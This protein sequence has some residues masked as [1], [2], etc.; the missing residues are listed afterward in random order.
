VDDVV[1]RGIVEAVDGGALMVRIPSLSVDA[2]H[3]AET[4]TAGLVAGDRVAVAFFDFADERAPL[5]LGRIVD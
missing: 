4:V 5:V 1:K 3:A 2:L